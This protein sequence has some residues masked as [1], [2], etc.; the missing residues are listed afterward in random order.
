MAKGDGLFWVMPVQKTAKEIYD[1]IKS[2][3]RIVYVTRRWKLIALFLRFI[4]TG[5]YK[6]IS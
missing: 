3:K 6:L 4:P 5:V 2:K 1:G